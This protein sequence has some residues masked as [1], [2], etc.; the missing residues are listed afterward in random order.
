MVD[1]KCFDFAKSGDNVGLITTGLDNISMPRSG[2]VIVYKKRF[3][4]AN[5]RASVGLNTKGLGDINMPWSGDVFVS[6][7]GF[8]F[9]DTGWTQV[10][11][12]VARYLVD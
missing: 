3:D 4:S 9:R 10:G 7:K 2:D 5:C 1:T 11:R 8:N 6:K 12:S